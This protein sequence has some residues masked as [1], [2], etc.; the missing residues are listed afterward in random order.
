MDNCNH[1][2]WRIS[3]NFKNK[4]ELATNYQGKIENIEISLK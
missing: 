2:E 4:Y 3:Q 1:K